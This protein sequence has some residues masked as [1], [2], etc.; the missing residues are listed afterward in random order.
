MTIATYD[1]MTLGRWLPA[2]V[3]RVLWLDG[4]LMVLHDLTD[5][6]AADSLVIA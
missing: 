2:S 1:K 3:E 5:L 6:W 4:D